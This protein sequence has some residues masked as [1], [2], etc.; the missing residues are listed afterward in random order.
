MQKL[1]EMLKNS[2]QLAQENIKRIQEIRR[3]LDMRKA[4]STQKSA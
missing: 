4:R 2:D 3:T 1:A